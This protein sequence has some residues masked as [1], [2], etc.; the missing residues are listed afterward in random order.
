MDEN[1]KVYLYK[2][3]DYLKL[4]CSDK[5]LFNEWKTIL[6]KDIFKKIEEKLK[7]MRLNKMVLP[8]IVKNGAKGSDEENAENKN[9]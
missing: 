4:D 5:K 3:K 8:G 2:I 1:L 7:H 9:D 6:M